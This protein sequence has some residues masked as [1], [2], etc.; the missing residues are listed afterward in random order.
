V[1]DV[2]I[3]YR[4]PMYELWSG[5]KKRAPYVACYRGIEA[6]DSVQAREIAEGRFRDT[7]LESRVRWPREVVEVLVQAVLPT[8]SH[9]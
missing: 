9:R 7:A 4:E 5:S 1:F 3:R 2:K 8:S 6:L